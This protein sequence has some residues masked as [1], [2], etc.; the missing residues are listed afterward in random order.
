MLRMVA[1]DMDGTIGDTI[2]MCLRA[3]REAASPFLGRRLTDGE[4]VETFGLNEE[5]M[6]K[7]IAGGR[8]KPAIEEYYHLYEAIHD[9][10]VR[11]FPGIAELLG[12]LRE[13]GVKTA[14]ITGKGQRSCAIT[15]EK[16][17][18]GACFDAVW[19][20]SAEKM[21]KSE[22]MA[23]LLARFA[24]TPEETCYVG[25]A[26]SD[27]TASNQAGIRCLSAVWGGMADARTMGRVNAGNVVAT[28][29]ELK[30][31]LAAEISQ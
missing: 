19:T 20:G 11:M 22:C 27:V 23:E 21:N 6:M 2:P 30:A 5:G 12:W 31:R 25:D 28:V 15:L 26:L 14:L 4:I 7:A 17:G 10:S 13:R 18:I 9:E 3:F 16:F 8:W 1:F 29:E 24:L